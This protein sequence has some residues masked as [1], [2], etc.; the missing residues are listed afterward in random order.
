MVSIFIGEANVDGEP[1]KQHRLYAYDAVLVK[2]EYFWSN[3]EIDHIFHFSVSPPEIML[4]R[5]YY[6]NTCHILFGF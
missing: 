6:T 2:M 4:Y 5:D 3:H 1:N